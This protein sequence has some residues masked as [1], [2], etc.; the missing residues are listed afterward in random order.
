MKSFRII[1]IAFLFLLPISVLSQLNIDY[2]IQQGRQ[3]LY[4]Y[5]YSQ[6]IKTFNMVIEYRPYHAEAY[7]LRGIAKYNLQD[8]Y[9]AERIQGQCC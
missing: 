2:Y 9:G 5:R 7:F 3:Q 4:H 6:A 8:Y 1:C